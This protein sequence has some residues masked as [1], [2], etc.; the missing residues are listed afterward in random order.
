[1]QEYDFDLR[2]TMEQHGHSYC[3]GHTIEEVDGWRVGHIGARELKLTHDDRMVLLVIEQRKPDETGRAFRLSRRE[4]GGGDSE[5]LEEAAYFD[6]IWRY[7]MC[8]LCGVS[9]AVQSDDIE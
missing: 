6:D 1:M 8:Y 4:P 3:F 5:L 2:E 9:D 7:A